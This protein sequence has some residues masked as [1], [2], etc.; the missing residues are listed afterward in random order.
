MN[1]L[2]YQTPVMLARQWEK[3]VPADEPSKG[4][5]W[6]SKPQLAAEGL[7]SVMRKVSVAKTVPALPAA[8]QT[9]QAKHMVD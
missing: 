5:R 9:S 7:S 3:G 1:Y 4:L 8:S 2:R 6:L